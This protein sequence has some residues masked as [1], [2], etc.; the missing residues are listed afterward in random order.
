[1]PKVPTV[2]LNASPLPG[3]QAPGV[4]AYRSAVPRM[5]QEGGKAMEGLGK[6][7]TE[8]S[9]KVENDIHDANTLEAT[10]EAELTYNRSLQQHEALKGKEATDA[11]KGAL[12]DFDAA[13]S[14]IS[15][16]LHPIEQRQFKK[17]RDRLQGKHT[18]RVEAHHI[19]T[20]AEQKQQQLLAQQVV[21]ADNLINN[22]LTIS[23]TPIPTTGAGPLATPSIVSPEALSNFSRYLNNVKTQGEDLGLSGEA[24]E[25]FV[26]GH[27]DKL[28]GS[29]V[30]NKLDSEDPAQIQSVEDLMANLPEGLVSKTQQANLGKLVET[31]SI[32]SF[33]TQWSAREIQADTPYGDSLSRILEMAETDP[34]RAE[35]MMK[36]LNSFTQAKDK[37]ELEEEGSLRN[38]LSEKIQNGG[39]LT[40]KDRQDAAALGILDDLM[41]IERRLDVSTP[42]GNRLFVSLN[43]NPELMKRDYGSIDSMYAKLSPEMSNADIRV[44]A[45]QWGGSVGRSRGGSS[46]TQAFDEGE[47]NAKPEEVIQNE[48]RELDS[49]HAESSGG[50][51]LQER[52]DLYHHSDTDKGLRGRAT[53]MIDNRFHQD[54]LMKANELYKLRTANLGKGESI[55]KTVL[56]REAAKIVYESGWDNKEKTRNLY[57]SEFTWGTGSMDRPPTDEQLKSFLPEALKQLKVEQQNRVTES[58]LDQLIPG[59]KVMRIEEVINMANQDILGIGSENLRNFPFFRYPETASEAKTSRGVTPA[60]IVG[61]QKEIVDTMSPISPADA[62]V[63][64]S[65]LLAESKRQVLLKESKQT[66]RSQASIAKELLSSKMINSWIEHKRTASLPLVTS[67][68]E[69][70][71][72]EGNTETEPEDQGYQGFTVIRFVLGLFTGEEKISALPRSERSS[73]QRQGDWIRFVEE[74]T[75]LKDQYKGSLESWESFVLQFYPGHVKDLP[76][77][78]QATLRN[79]PRSTDTPAKWWPG[80]SGTTDTEAIE[81]FAP[82]FGT[83]DDKTMTR[84]EALREHYKVQK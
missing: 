31:K 22:D 24:L 35:A 80:K 10:N 40:A 21:L 1:M 55:N 66:A 39:T 70:W 32:E 53:A 20:A 8:I 4:T 29:V 74:S 65:G 52:L 3:F 9:L 44:L 7:A 77:S 56:L 38:A 27:V 46:R 42:Y 79:I 64:A 16:R 23:G 67:A 37:A 60:M 81:R 43:G 26:T 57:T 48:L 19:K 18:L 78:V 15:D 30:Q 2:G 83:N 6:V 72:A 59:N 75:D 49:L 82:L 14:I 54:V 63:R 62:K 76:K 17:A 5:I 11:K 45:A 33:A 58:V 36:K 51:T 69:K 28:I 13:M 47:F 50:K 71:E 84:F 73:S 41:L 25:V 68:R 61:R 12:D 34:K